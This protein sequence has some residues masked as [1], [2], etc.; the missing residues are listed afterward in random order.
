M[1]VFFAAA[2]ICAGTAQADIVVEFRD[3]APKDRFTITNDSPC[4]TGAIVGLSLDLVTA[5]AGVIFDVTGAGAGVEVFQ[6]FEVIQGANYLLS[7]SD[8]MNGDQFLSLLLADMPAGAQVAFT[9]DLDDTSGGREITV[10]GSEIAGALAL[11]TT[12]SDSLAAEF[13]E[14]GVAR[15]ATACPG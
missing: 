8:T 3:G 6:P 11:L 13:D 10:H 1:R 15:I 7:V 5:P 2:L 14:T 9:L 12:T 4:A